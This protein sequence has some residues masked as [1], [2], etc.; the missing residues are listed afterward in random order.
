MLQ[1]EDRRIECCYRRPEERGEKLPTRQKRIIEFPKNPR[2]GIQNS[3]QEDKRI[4]RNE[5]RE[6][7]RYRNTC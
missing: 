3:G 2:R 4:R 6:R 1:R 7:S 5:E